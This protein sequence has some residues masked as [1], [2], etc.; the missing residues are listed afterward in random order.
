MFNIETE[1]NHTYVAEGVVVHNCDTSYTW[2]FKESGKKLE[3]KYSLPV[4]RKEYS[5]DMSVEE[6]VLA[7][8][9]AAGKIRRVVFTGGEPLLQQKNLIKVMNELEKTGEEWFF[10]IET[11]GTILFDDNFIVNQINCSP[12]LGSSGNLKASREKPEV[13]RDILEQGM[14]GLKIC[15]KFV[16]GANTFKEDIK[17]IRMWEKENKV[18]RSLIYLMPEGITTEDVRKGTVELIDKCLKY[19]YKISTRLQVLLYGVKRAV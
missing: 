15:F 12:K 7:I 3:H 4:S 14:F 9:K 17:E 11:N 2:Y 8:H 19:G 6:V 5:L 18:P 16:V 1:K 10:E 13:I